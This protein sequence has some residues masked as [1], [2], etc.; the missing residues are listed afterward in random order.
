MFHEEWIFKIMD[1]ICNKN[2]NFNAYW[3]LFAN[4]FKRIIFNAEK[5]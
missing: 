3:Q 4:F 5:Q 1:V 2:I